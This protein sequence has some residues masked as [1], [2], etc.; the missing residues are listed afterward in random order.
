M[1]SLST[2][3]CDGEFPSPCGPPKSWSQ[4]Y[5]RQLL[6]PKTLCANLQGLDEKSVAT[7]LKCV[8][9]GVEHLHK[10]GIIHRDIKVGQCAKTQ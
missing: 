5:E 6:H 9:Q 10:H 8:L 2:H 3:S 1:D 4:K 7:I